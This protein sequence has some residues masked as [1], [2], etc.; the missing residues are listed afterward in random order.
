M[1]T[2]SVENLTCAYDGQVVLRDLCLAARPGE[3]L[4]LI[5]PTR[6]YTEVE[7]EA[8]D[9][10]LDR[11]GRLLVALDP[12]IEPGGTMRPTRLEAFLTDRSDG[13]R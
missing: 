5:G 12:L 3:V 2:L 11:G 10:F 9:A 13:S 8:L 6:A 1:K 4:A 7:I